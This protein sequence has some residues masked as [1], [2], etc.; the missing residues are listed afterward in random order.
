MKRILSAIFIICIV[1]F[2]FAGC[3]PKIENKSLVDFSVYE[4]VNSISDI[5]RINLPSKY[6]KHCT[7]YKFTY[8]SDGFD[9]KAYISI[10][11]DCSSENPK[12]C[13]LYNRGGN[14]KIGLL[15][16]TD[17]AKICTATGRVVIASQYRGCDSGT[18]KDEFGGADL[19]DIIT[20][21][22]FCENTFDFTTMT[23]FCTA[24]VSRGGMMSYMLARCDQ[25]VKRIIAISAVSNLTKVYNEREDMHP[26]L[27][28]CIGGPPQLLP[29]EYENRSVIFWANEITIP[30][31]MIHSKGDVQ[32]S[33][34][35]AEELKAQFDKN[36]TPCKFISYNDSTHGFHE[37]DISIIKDWLTK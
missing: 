33:Y 2:V 9:V 8:N 10:P 20:L 35:Q 5:Q 34:S 17:T 15:T 13:I 23:D 7:S 26:L 27:E 36:N 25:R 37:E 22:D 14:F 31:L 16:D 24:G 3:S 21:V 28:E 32:V 29:L 19:N 4:G 12:E 18:G 30:V 1:I 11:L 6:E